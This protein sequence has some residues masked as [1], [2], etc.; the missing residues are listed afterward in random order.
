M[1]EP[2]IK[3]IQKLGSEL[4]AKDKAVAALTDKMRLE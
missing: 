4:D 3:K 1:L 2:K